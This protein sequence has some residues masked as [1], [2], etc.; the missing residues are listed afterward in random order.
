VAGML[1][2][3]GFGSVEVHPAWDGLPLRDAEEW[4]VYAGIAD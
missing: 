3:A 1:S 2:A 4:A